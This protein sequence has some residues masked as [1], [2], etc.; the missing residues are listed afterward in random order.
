MKRLETYSFDEII[1]KCGLRC[2]MPEAETRGTLFTAD[3]L[4]KTGDIE[5]AEEDDQ[6]VHPA[7]DEPRDVG[8]Q[9][10]ALGMTSPKDRKA[11]FANW[12]GTFRA[13][14]KI[15]DLRLPARF[16]FSGTM[17]SGLAASANAAKPSQIMRP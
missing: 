12:R 1:M 8:D 16:A 10:Q 2:A 17:A 5:A 15:V 7:E 9:S 6:P 3:L 11:A 14:G 13:P 4:I